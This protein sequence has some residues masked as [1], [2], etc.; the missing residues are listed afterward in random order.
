VI[1]NHDSA[2]DRNYLFVFVFPKVKKADQFAPCGSPKS[3]SVEEDKRMAIAFKL[4]IIVGQYSDAT[5]YK[6]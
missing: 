6:K 4:K 1:K 2:E 5:W 3:P